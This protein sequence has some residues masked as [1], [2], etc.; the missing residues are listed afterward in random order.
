MF[1]F[2]RST[3][4]QRLVARLVRESFREHKF[5][6]GAAIVS[7]LVVAAMTGASAWILKEIT[8]EFVVYKR[9]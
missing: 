7:M 1:F 9:A 8:N 5:G 6:Y 4:N 2:F 3:E